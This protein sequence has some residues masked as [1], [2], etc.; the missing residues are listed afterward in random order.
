MPREMSA[1]RFLACVGT[2]WGLVVAVCLGGVDGGIRDAL[3]WRS[4][5]GTTECPPPPGAAYACPAATGTVAARRQALEALRTTYAPVDDWLVALS[6]V[7][8]ASEA[9]GGQADHDPGRAEPPPPGHFTPSSASPSSLA[10]GRQM[11]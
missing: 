8:T 9:L 6:R 7:R 2:T 11:P 3:A 10:F 1:G 4:P 5:P